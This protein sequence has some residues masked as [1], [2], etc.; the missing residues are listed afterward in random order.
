[1]NDIREYLA[2]LGDPDIILF[3]GL[4]DA[5]IGL[6]EAFGK[7]PVVVYDYDKCIELLE[8]PNQEDPEKRYFDACE[9]FDY[10]VIG[11]YVGKCTPVFLRR[12]EGK[13]GLHAAVMQIK[14]LWD[15]LD[16]EHRNQVTQHI[17][18]EK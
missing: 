1:M 14:Q 13:A 16:E 10:N 11:A 12:P 2:E 7:G 6:Q 8:D 5:I 3:D 18:G 15:S 17:Q 4:D 9:H